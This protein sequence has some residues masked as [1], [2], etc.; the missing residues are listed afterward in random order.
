MLTSYSFIQ[1]LVC[2][3]NTYETN[4]HQISYFVL[5]LLIFANICLV[6][7]CLD[8]DLHYREFNTIGYSPIARPVFNNNQTVLI[9]M[10]IALA[11]VVEL[12]R[13][14]SM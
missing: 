14:S 11:Q 6:V 4:Y 12:V 8:G 10:N 13:N 3:N 2:K 1:I 5:C 7:I 9:R